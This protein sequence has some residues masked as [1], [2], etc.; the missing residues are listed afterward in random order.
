MIFIACRES[1]PERCFALPTDPALRPPSQHTIHKEEIILARNCTVWSLASLHCQDMRQV[2]RS[3]DSTNTQ[4]SS[5][6]RRSSLSLFVPA[7]VPFQRRTKVQRNCRDYRFADPKKTLD[8][9]LYS[10]A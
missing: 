10:S 8:S 4:N 3:K 5:P 6:G 1:E 9:G 2:L 7:A